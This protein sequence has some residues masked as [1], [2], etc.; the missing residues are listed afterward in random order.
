MAGDGLSR[1]VSFWGMV[2]AVMVALKLKERYDDYNSLPG[3][4]DGLGHGPVAL[5]TPNMDEDAPDGASLLDTQLP[6]R[7]TRQRKRDCCMCCGMRCGLFWKAFG[8]VCGLFLIWQAV[9]LA[10][11]AFTPKPT[12]LEDM[13]EFSV[14]LGQDILVPVGKHENRG[15][16]SVDFRGSAVGTIVL[17]QGEADLTDIKYELT[18]RA[19][20]QDV[21][22]QTILDYPTADEVEDGMKSS[23]VQVITPPRTPETANSCVRF[24]AV[25][26]LPPAVRT[27]HVQSHVATQIKFDPDSN[28]DFDSLIVTL[29]GLDEKNML[30]PT[31]GIHA[32]HTKL[33]ITRGW[34]VG[35]VTVVDEAELITQRGDA[36]LHVRVHPAP[37]SAE[38]PA[39]VK[40]LTS[41]GAGRTDVFFVNHPG[42]PHRPID[43]THHSSMNGEMYLT[44]TDAAFNGTV[45]FAAKSFSAT[46]LQNA[47]KKDGGLPYVGSQ[48]G[49]DQMAVRTQGW[50]GL[51]F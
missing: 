29:Y 39:P 49:G 19:D 10:V 38:P 37:S 4:E 35:D 42:F 11:W 51:Y 18:L 22:D 1:G 23:R 21:L 30:L 15:D 6:T 43:A 27:L 33:Q 13:P 48:E 32:K 8:I 36:H 34:F 17:A 7:S 12:G 46:G 45:D 24:D 40:L 41:T 50:A 16:H 26:Y 31:E 44:Y 14:S 3:D 47:F 2:G 25:I 5:R 28:F 9:R 20:S